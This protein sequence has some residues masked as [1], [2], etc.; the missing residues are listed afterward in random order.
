MPEVSICSVPSAAELPDCSP[1]FPLSFVVLMI[2]LIDVIE[3]LEGRV[4]G[5]AGMS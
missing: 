4:T 5:L 2:R 1:H 3:V